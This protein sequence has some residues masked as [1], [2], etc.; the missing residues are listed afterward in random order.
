MEGRRRLEYE[1]E[2]KDEGRSLRSYL[3]GKGFSRHFL[4]GLRNKDKVLVDG[5]L[6]MFW[7][8][9]HAGQHVSV[10]PYSD[11]AS[12]VEPVEMDLEILY[13]DA[14]Y[15]ALNKP[16]DMA[17]HPVK[18]FKRDTLANGVQRHLNRQGI[19]SV[20]PVSR[21]DK[22]TSGVI[23]YAKHPLAQHV[24][25]EAR[26]TKEYVALVEGR[27][28]KER[29]LID[30]PIGKADGPT[31]R[32]EVR[33]DGQEAHTEYEVLSSNDTYSLLRIRLHTGRTHQIRVHLSHIGHPLVGDFL[34]GKENAP[35]LFLHSRRLCFRH[36]RLG[37]ELCIEAPLPDLFTSYL[38]EA[39]GK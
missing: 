16:Y 1:V 25:T 22:T 39:S 23:L 7:I 6:Q 29:D 33:P 28:L 26:T 35:R 2:E 14:D 11:E 30:L 4:I 38:E 18:A 36:F 10:D 37:R 15:I 8:P 21:L 31:I 9:L 20:H 19:A 3:E 5:G 24:L 17:T 34:Y 12:L 13:E 27:V 32:R